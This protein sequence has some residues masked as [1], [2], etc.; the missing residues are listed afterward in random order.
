MGDC[1]V[2]AGLSGRRVSTLEGRRAVVTG[3]TKGTWAGIVAR[4]RSAG[5]PDAVDGPLPGTE[6]LHGF[7][8]QM[9]QHERQRGRSSMSRPAQI[10][11]SSRDA[12][13]FHLMQLG[14]VVSAAC[15]VAASSSEG[16]GGVARR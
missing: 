5:A 9:Q 4:L 1:V 14:L 12:R 15:S 10:T 11:Q 6:S 7:S 2:L 3:G 8:Q 13:T 16:R